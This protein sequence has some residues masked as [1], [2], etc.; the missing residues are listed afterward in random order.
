MVWSET[1]SSINYTGCSSISG[2][3]TSENMG[4]TLYPQAYLAEINSC[5]VSR[6]PKTIAAKFL[7]T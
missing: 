2:H 3:I 5:M 7:I 6:G 1:K 4:D